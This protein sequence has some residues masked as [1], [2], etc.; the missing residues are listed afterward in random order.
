MKF[1]FNNL[2]NTSVFGIEF[3]NSPKQKMLVFDFH[4]YSFAMIWNLKNDEEKK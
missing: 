2:K 3:S 4:T 1:K